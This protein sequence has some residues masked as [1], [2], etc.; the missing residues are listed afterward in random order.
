MQAAKGQKARKAPNLTN[1]FNHAKHRKTGLHY[2][3]ILGN[4]PKI[5]I[6]L[7]FLQRISISDFSS[8]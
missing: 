2:K 5:L 1:F 8:F 4:F 6:F 7:K 3:H